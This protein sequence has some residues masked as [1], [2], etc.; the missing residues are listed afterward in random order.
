MNEKIDQLLREEK[1]RLEDGAKTK[2]LDSGAS[3]ISYM[4][5]SIKRCFSL[6]KNQPA[7]DMLTVLRKNIH[8]Y[9]S[10]VSAKVSM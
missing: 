5:K 4:K 10:R 9:L 7:F 3:F 8:G 6:T 2:I 1:W